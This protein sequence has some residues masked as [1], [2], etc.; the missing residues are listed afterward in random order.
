MNKLA[1][2]LI[3]VP[4]RLSNSTSSYYLW[5][6]NFIFTHHQDQRAPVSSRLL[7]VLIWY[8]QT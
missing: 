1:E 7:M 8:C 4:C 2:T 5:R 6:F 3:G